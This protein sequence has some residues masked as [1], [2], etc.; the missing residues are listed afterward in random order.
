MCI[1]NIVHQ[2]ITIMSRALIVLIAVFFIQLNGVGQNTESIQEKYDFLIEKFDDLKTENSD[3]ARAEAL[4]DAIVK[5]RTANPKLAKMLVDTCE[6]FTI[7]HKLRLQ[8]ARVIA[9]KAFFARM[10]GRDESFVNYQLEAIDI[11]NELKDETSDSVKVIMMNERISASLNNIAGMYLAKEQFDQA[12][13]FYLNSLN[14]LGDSRDTLAFSI[15]YYNIGDTYANKGIYDSALYYM[16]LS[17]SL[18]EEMNSSEGLAYAY[19]GMGEIYFKMEKYD[20]SVS[21]LITSLFYIREFKEPFLEV[22][23]MDRLASNYLKLGQPE[24]AYDYYVQAYSK[25][26]EIGMVE[27]YPSA[28]KGLSDVDFKL[29][30]YKSAYKNL[31]DYGDLKDSLNRIEQEDV[32]AEFRTQYET[33]K[34]DEQI[35]V[36]NE[37]KRIISEREEA[38][39]AKQKADEEKRKIINYSFLVGVLFLLLIGVLLLKGYLQKKKHNKTLEGKNESLVAKN[40]EIN[41]QREKLKEQAEEIKDSINY[42][43]GIQNSILP[44]KDEMNTIFSKHF[45]Y[46]SPKDIVS[47]DFYWL[48]HLPDDNLSFFAVADCTG[49]G[50]P[51]A[52]MSVLGHALLD[53]IIKQLDVRQTDEVLKQLSIELFEKLKIGG[54]KETRDGMDIALVKIDHKNKHVQFSGARNSL[55]VYRGDELI[56]FKGDRA[57][58]GSVETNSKL[59]Q[60]VLEVEPNDTFF[61]FTDGFPDQKGGERNKKFFMQPL[62]ELFYEVSTMSSEKSVEKLHSTFVNW[63]GDNEQLDDVLIVGFKLK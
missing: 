2:G 4:I 21:N 11:Y 31:L 38:L 41:K 24:S 33:E 26:Q 44:T 52:F 9:H 36:L 5:E 17:K 29:G 23:C 45:Q 27:Y 58:L 39:K 54:V 47:G 51:G 35:R 62:R 19:F 55:I 15:R 10:E 30:N 6:Q 42:A 12:L 13:E 50:V 60:T 20:E 40:T 3:T 14:S 16:N 25:A 8:Y 61:M 37:Q 22:Q 32:L 56:E 43:K 53:K 49:H 63:K 1:F 7:K 57:D 48:T 59:T 46:Y 28:L 34:K 18:E